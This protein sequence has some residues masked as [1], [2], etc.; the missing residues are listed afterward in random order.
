MV[1]A[2]DDVLVLCSRDLLH[3]I[4][5]T[6]D[7]TG[8]PTGAALQRLIPLTAPDLRLLLNPW[9]RY[10]GS[11]SLISCHYCAPDDGVPHIFVSC[12]EEYFLVH[13][14]KPY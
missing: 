12:G 13:L 8:T 10:N 5:L 2:A 14:N 7:S 4:G 3:F 1:Y 11:L 9:A 6:K